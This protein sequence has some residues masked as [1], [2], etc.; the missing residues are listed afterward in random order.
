MPKAKPLSLYPLSFED[1]IKAI[2]SADPDRV[3]L[4]SK[5]RKRRKRSVTRSSE[6][7]KQGEHTPAT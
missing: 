2:A 1:A 6:P 4:T 5:R 3:G 7:P